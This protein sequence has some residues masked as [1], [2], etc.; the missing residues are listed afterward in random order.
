MSLENDRQLLAAGDQVGQCSQAIPLHQ[1]VLLS[2]S[3]CFCVT[4]IAFEAC[5][6]R[7]LLDDVSD[8]L[9]NEF[10]YILQMSL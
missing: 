3:G 4:S 7:P 1:L 8:T 2:R 9:S 5:Y 6:Q 10:L